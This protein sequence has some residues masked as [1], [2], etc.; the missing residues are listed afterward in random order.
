MLWN[1]CQLSAHLCSA[2]RAAVQRISP[3]TAFGII[4]VGCWWW[5]TRMG[6]KKLPLT[7]GPDPCC[8]LCS[9]EKHLNVWNMCKNKHR[10]SWI[11]TE[12]LGYRLLH[13]KNR[14]G[15]ETLTTLFAFVWGVKLH[16]LLPHQLF[17]FITQIKSLWTD[18]QGVKF[19]MLQL[20]KHSALN[21][22]KSG[23]WIWPRKGGWASNIAS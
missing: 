17:D 23:I 8:C 21:F 3:Q 19:M 11:R 12:I 18:P 7:T 15:E 16:Y 4:H 10:L 13:E 2:G 20:E 1:A 9:D 5:F 14:H 22:S 6:G